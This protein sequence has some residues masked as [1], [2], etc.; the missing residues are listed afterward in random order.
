MSGNNQSIK[1]NFTAGQVSPLIYG[2]GDLNIFENG[3][4]NIENVIIYPTG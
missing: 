4:R 3:A 2:R 1:T